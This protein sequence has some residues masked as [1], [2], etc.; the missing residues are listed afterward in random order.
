MNTQQQQH[1][2]SQLQP[3][4]PVIGFPLTPQ[5]TSSK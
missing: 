5:Q 4:S 3:R 1:Q 2:R